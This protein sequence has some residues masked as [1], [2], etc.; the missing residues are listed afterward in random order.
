MSLSV[1]TDIVLPLLA[2]EGWDGRPGRLP[3]ARG[4]R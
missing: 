3:P 2:E 4:T 1:Q